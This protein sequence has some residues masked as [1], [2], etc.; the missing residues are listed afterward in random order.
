MLANTVV[1]ER[2]KTLGI[3]P[4]DNSTLLKNSGVILSKIYFG[5]YGS[6]VFVIAVLRVAQKLELVITATS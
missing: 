2:H 1:M 4:W 3:T 5:D 6:G